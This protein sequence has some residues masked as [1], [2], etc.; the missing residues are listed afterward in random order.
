[1]LKKEQENG[2]SFIIYDIYDNDYPTKKPPTIL[3]VHSPSPKISCMIADD[4][5]YQGGEN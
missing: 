3:E 4:E 5:Y 2:Q 1:M